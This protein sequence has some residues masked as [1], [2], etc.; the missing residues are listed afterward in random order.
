MMT[1]AV[2]MTMT[3]ILVEVCD[4]DVNIWSSSLIYGDPQFDY[5]YSQFIYGFMD[6]IFS[7][8]Y[9]QYSTQTRFGS[10]LWLTHQSNY[11]HHK[12]IRPL[13]YLIAYD[14]QQIDSYISQGFH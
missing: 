14:I 13:Q 5:K 9:I 3:V 1:M 4:V 11:L 8:P 2:T 12:M 10:P 6:M 7:F